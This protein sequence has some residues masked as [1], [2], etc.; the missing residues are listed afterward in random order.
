[1]STRN[2]LVSESSRILR[3]GVDLI[4]SLD[5]ELY[6]RSQ[7][8][9]AASGIGGHI[10][11]CIDHVQCFLGGLEGGRI[12]YDGRRR[13]LRVETDRA[14]AIERLREVIAGLEALGRKPAPASVSRGGELAVKM[15]VPEG[16]EPFWTTSSV[17]RELQSLTSHTVHHFALIAFLVRLG[18]ASTTED[19]GVALS[20]LAYW[21]E[22]NAPAGRATP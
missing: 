13:D 6:A 9:V 8:P 11:H 1:M 14:Y 12:D 3:Q 20:T 5:D 18:G 2:L 19:F 17:E 22:Q 15:D 7:E 16:A 21:K 10:R 4:E